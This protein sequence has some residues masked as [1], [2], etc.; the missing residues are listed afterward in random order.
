MGKDNIRYS[1]FASQDI[2]SKLK[3]GI[4]PLPERIFEYWS[5]NLRREWE[6]WITGDVYIYEPS[7]MESF[8]KPRGISHECLIRKDGTNYCR[9]I[10]EDSVDR[11]KDKYT[12]QDIKRPSGERVTREEYLDEMSRLSLKQNDRDVQQAMNTI[13][14]MDT[15]KNNKL[16]VIN[17]LRSHRYYEVSMSC[18]RSIKLDTDA[19]TLV[20]NAIELEKEASESHDRK[21]LDIAGRLYIDSE[22]LKKQSDIEF[23]R[24]IL[25]DF[26][27]N[28]K[29]NGDKFRS[30][31]SSLMAA[32]YFTNL[33]DTDYEE[34]IGYLDVVFLKKGL[35]DVIEFLLKMKDTRIEYSDTYLTRINSQTEMP[36]LVL[37]ETFF[38]YKTYGKDKK[39]LELDQT[40][41]ILYR[42]P[43]VKE[44]KKAKWHEFSHVLLQP[45]T[46]TVDEETL[47][48][49]TAHY[50]DDLLGNSGVHDR[51]LK[52]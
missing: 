44:F 41:I 30:K 9:E 23:Q 15:T 1:V 50:T 52:I 40:R 39:Y 48:E 36:E 42:S 46:G 35:N 26:F 20:K 29:D 7:E 4:N 21:L 28:V 18:M 6:D 11:S 37:G 19:N 22:I 10:A 31:L 24:A 3:N 49:K 51:K 8:G 13:L 38:R 27:A 45:F 14:K 2:V 32:H 25:L 34:M 33:K 17:E 43:I 16:E 12:I 5:F 47:K